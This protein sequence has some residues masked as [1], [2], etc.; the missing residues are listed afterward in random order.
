MNC[1]LKLI[2]LRCLWRQLW[3]TCS[4]VELT[5]YSHLVTNGQW[6][7][8]S[9]DFNDLYCSS[10]LP[11]QKSSYLLPTQMPNSP[12][13]SCFSPHGYVFKL[14][15]WLP[16][17]WGATIPRGSLE[18]SDNLLHHD[19]YAW[20]HNDAKSVNSFNL[21]QL[22][23]YRSVTET[24]VSD[25]LWW[26]REDEESTGLKIRGGHFLNCCSIRAWTN[27]LERKVFPKLGPH[28][29]ITWCTYSY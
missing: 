25:T 16:V 23:T 4:D 6:R 9:P 17:P 15:F 13:T 18:L 27:S 14:G 24:V 7:V 12:R 5:L 26:F 3:V 29:Q 2:S 28:F 11:A 20:D 10:S 19:T 21:H 22:W 8:S 1:F